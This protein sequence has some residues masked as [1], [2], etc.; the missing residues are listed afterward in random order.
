MARKSNPLAFQTGSD[1]FGLIAMSLR[2][3]RDRT[4]HTASLRFYSDGRMEL[5]DED[6]KP[7]PSLLFLAREFAGLLQYLREDHLWPIPD[8]K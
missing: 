7:R 1:V 4:Y 2:K 8:P 6:T 3:Y 5:W